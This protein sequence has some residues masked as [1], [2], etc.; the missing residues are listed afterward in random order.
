MCR[1]LFQCLQESIESRSTEHMHFVDDVY[2][3]FPYLRQNPHLLYQSADIV[4]A[5]IGSGIQFVNI[6]RTPGIESLTGFAFVTR[7]CIGLQI[8][9]IDRFR[10]NTGTS[11][12]TDPSGTGKQIG[13]SQLMVHNGIPQSGSNSQLP[14]HRIET[15]R[16][17]FSRRNNKIFHKQSTIYPN[18]GFTPSG[19]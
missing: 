6:Q 14:H 10:K 19:L 2:A 18:N 1:R 17:V 3:V 9:A 5:V 11:R 7:L 8:Q 16:P 15:R 4:H 12:L 13:L